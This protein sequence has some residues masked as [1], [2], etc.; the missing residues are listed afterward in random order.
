MSMISL[1]LLALAAPAMTFDQLA[2]RC[3]A[4]HKRATA[5]AFS[6]AFSSTGTEQNRSGTYEVGYRRPDRLRYRAR[7]AP[8]AKSG[9]VDQSFILV[10][11]SLYGIDHLTNQMLQRKVTAKGTLTER[12]QSAI[13]LDEPI[14]IAADSVGLELFLSPLRELRGWKITERGDNREAVAQTPSG[15][16]EVTF[17]KATGRLS[18]VAIRSGAAGL[19][20]AYSNWKSAPGSFTVPT[21][22]RRV[23][24]FY[25]LPPYPKA[26]DVATSNLLNA[27]FA[28]HGR[29]RYAN[30]RVTDASG[31]TTVWL[32]DGAARQVDARGQWT[33]SGGTLRYAKR[34]SSPQTRKAKLRDVE[35]TLA[36]QGLEIE[37]MLHRWLQGRN[38]LST[39]WKADL[40]ARVR[41]EL[42][43]GK[44]RGTILELRAPGIRI[45]A[46]IR[47]DTN[48]IHS[49]TTEN[50]DSASKVVAS[51]ERRFEYLSVGKPLPKF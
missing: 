3:L 9:P 16:F 26:S 18:A 15:R 21:T 30:Y 5:G 47:R 50:L 13:A 10:G 43:V 28:A 36:Q 34:G 22:Y 4:V 40:Q 49:L 14:R 42:T 1:G 27:T 7:M 20:W 35:T 37:P 45:T 29:L 39:M 41:G 6:V 32:N 44:M 12:F 33:W 23:N 24:E 38:P 48:L 8:T 2:D 51:F 31:V 17:S 11:S 25:E 46:I 19:R